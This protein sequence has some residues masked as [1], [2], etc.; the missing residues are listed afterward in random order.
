MEHANNASNIQANKVT[1]KV[2]KN[3]CERYFKVEL[4]PS[5]PN[6]LQKM[7][8]YIANIQLKG[9]IMK[10]KMMVKCM[11]DIFTCIYKN[12]EP[13]VKLLHRTTWKNIHTNE[14]K[15]SLPYMNN[16]IVMYD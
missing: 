8:L 9:I 15:Q 16:M 13:E 7:L 10:K 14:N 3:S 11:N 5:L 6:A 2:T 12:L 1:Q 4:Y